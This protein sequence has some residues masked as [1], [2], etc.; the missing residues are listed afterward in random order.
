[1]G[2]DDHNPLEIQ[3][4]H[5]KLLENSVQGLALNLFFLTHF[6]RKFNAFS[7]LAH[8]HFSANG[9]KL[10]C[11]SGFARPG[12]KA[13]MRKNHKAWIIS[14]TG[15]ALHL[16][17]Y[18]AGKPFFAQEQGD[19]VVGA[20]GRAPDRPASFY[21]KTMGPPAGILFPPMLFAHNGLASRPQANFSVEEKGIKVKGGRG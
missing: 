21:G 15:R 19:S 20:P 3:I 12:S 18:R 1:M 7:L 6:M 17:W 9:R 4:V 16:A 10:Y 2:K 14:W 5:R 11:I 13:V 8:L